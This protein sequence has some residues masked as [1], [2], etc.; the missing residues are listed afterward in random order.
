MVFLVIWWKEG[1]KWRVVGEAEREE[2]HGKGEGEEESGRSGDQ[3]TT[4]ASAWP[5]GDSTSATTPAQH[6]GHQG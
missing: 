1:H 4:P 2:R 6:P 3:H 5:Q